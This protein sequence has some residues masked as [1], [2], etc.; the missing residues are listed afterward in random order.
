MSCLN[1]QEVVREHRVR[2]LV[3]ALAASYYQ[4]ELL[5]PLQFETA[6][7]AVFWG[8]HPVPL[9]IIFSQ[10]VSLFILAQHVTENFLIF[11][12]LVVVLNV[13]VLIF[14][15]RIKEA[16]RKLVEHCNEVFDPEVLLHLKIC[17]FY[18]LQTLENQIE[19]LG[20]VSTEIDDVELSC[21]KSVS[22]QKQR[23]V[24]AY[25]L[26]LRVL[27][28]VYESFVNFLNLNSV[29][30]L[31]SGRLCYLFKL[32]TRLQKLWK[33]ELLVA[34]RLFHLEELSCEHEAVLK[35]CQSIIF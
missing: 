4:V 8:P 3:S 26:K 15:L 34:L 19:T 24:V 16:I 21:S 18:L 25:F 12:L 9:R 30:L 13:R 6:E 20:K 14:Y 29:V 32:Y 31:A 1:W 23:Q 10:T 27:A 5:K 7:V 28:N 11:S 33:E 35:S 17:I 2:R 22:H